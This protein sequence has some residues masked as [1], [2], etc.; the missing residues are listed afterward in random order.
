[1]DRILILT[2]TQMTP[3]DFCVYTAENLDNNFLDCNLDLISITC[4]PCC[5]PR[6]RMSL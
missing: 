4:E 2:R 6:N 1:M 3:N 5:E